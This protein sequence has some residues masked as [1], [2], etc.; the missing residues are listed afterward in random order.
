MERRIK[1]TEKQWSELYNG[2]SKKNDY[3]VAI[4]SGTDIILF[5]TVKEAREF[6][7]QMKKTFNTK[8]GIGR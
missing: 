4:A 6:N 2:K 3:F 1:I 7:N 8:L 5:D